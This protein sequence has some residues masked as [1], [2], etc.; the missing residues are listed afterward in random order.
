VALRFRSR[1]MPAPE[2]P[3]TSSPF[4]TAEA[5]VAQGEYRAAIASLS[6]TNRVL[7]DVAIERRLA[8]LRLETFIAEQAHRSPA[9]DQWPPPVPADDPFAGQIGVP[10]VAAED[11]DGSTVRSGVIGHGALIVRGLLGPEAVATLRGAI[12]GAFAGAA[13]YY[14]SGPEPDDP[15]FSVYDPE[16]NLPD[17]LSHGRDFVWQG[18]GV[19]ACD[20]PRALQLIID[21]L[22]ASG[23][24]D[25]VEAHLGE[26]PAMSC[27]KTT[28]RDVPPD[29]WGGWHQDGAFLGDDI[30]ALNVWVALSDCGVDA[31]SLD[32]VARR[33]HTI[34]PTGTEGAHFSWS[35]SDAVAMEAA[36]EAGIE[37]PVFAA[38]DAILFDEMNLHRTGHGPHLTE[39]RFALE[40]WFFAPTNYPLDQVPLAV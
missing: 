37:T 21:A 20:S 22:D 4:E 35:V 19:L 16:P 7:P 23:V 12:D 11:L 28:L 40:C 39:H 13:R 8:R 17:M 32:I 14:G 18:G 27:R 36:G 5:L 30:R 15:W 34:V 3:E 2:L 24:I 1:R 31:S 10:E 6:A 33:L 29:T 26:R 25:A 38:G 9:G